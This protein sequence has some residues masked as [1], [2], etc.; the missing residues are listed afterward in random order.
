ML[1][2]P[3]VRK[4]ILMEGINDIGR[5]AQGGFEFEG[6]LA[7][8]QLI[9]VDKQIIARA[10]ARGIQVIGATLTPFEGAHYYDE[11]GETM[12]TAL[13]DWIRNS[14]AFDGVIDFDKAVQDPAHPIA[15][16]AAFNKYDHLHPNDTGYEA[17]ANAIDLKLI[18]G[19]AA[20]RQERKNETR[21]HRTHRRADRRAAAGGSIGAKP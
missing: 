15:I 10:H 2:V 20:M 5:P 19:Q 12:R 13:N 3:G 1:S 21:A 18:T 8:E 17:M 16:K 6:P 14:G 7:V 9:A 4:I 11:R